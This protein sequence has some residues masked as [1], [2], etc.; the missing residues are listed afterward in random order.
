M[1]LCVQYK[2]KPIEQSSKLRK[3]GLKTLEGQLFDVI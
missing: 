2:K 1:Y 3:H